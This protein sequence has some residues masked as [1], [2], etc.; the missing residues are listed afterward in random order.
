MPD[1]GRFVRSG[2]P[3]RGGSIQYRRV[4]P[5]WLV[6]E[7]YGLSSRAFRINVVRSADTPGAW[8]LE[9]CY[10]YLG[11]EQDAERANAFL[12]GYVGSRDPQPNLN[13]A[14]ALIR[15]IWLDWIYRLRE[16]VNA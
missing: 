10:V 11:V 4:E 13:S 16:P 8:V 14:K 5:G 15:E 1:V 9:P 6:A 3:I 7:V 2:I 12:D